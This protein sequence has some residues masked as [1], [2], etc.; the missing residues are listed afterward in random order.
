M[1]SIAAR[2]AGAHPDLVTG[3]LPPPWRAIVVPLAGWSGLVLAGHVLI[4]SL[5]AAGRDIGLRAPPL[6]G[7]VE[8]RPSLRLAA[9]LGVAAAVVL[10]GPPLAARMPWRRLVLLSAAMA[11]AWAVALA[12]VDG[13]DRLT[14][15]P[16]SPSGYLAVAERLVSPGAF[17]SSFT[18]RL[19]SY[20]IHVQGHP[21]GLVTA[22]WG[23][24]RVGLGGP[25]LLAALSIAGGGAAVAA[26]LVGAREVAGEP[27][28][29]RAAPFVVLAPAAVWVAT[30]GD[31][32]FAGIGAWAVTLVVLATG[33]FERR[34]DG[35]A[36]AGG[37]LF[38][39][40]AFLSYGLVLLALIPTAVAW[41][42]RRLRPLVVAAAG[43]APVALA[44]LAGGFWWF[45]GLHA[46]RERY[47]AGVGGRRPYG[48]FLV[49]DLAV[50][51]L[52][53]GP[54][55]AVGLAR[56]R[57]RA[58]WLLVGGALAAIA[59]ADVS[60]MSK[61]EVE[62]IWL[63]FMP[64]VLLAGAALYRVERDRADR[65]RVWLSLQA[66]VAITIQ[67]LVRSPW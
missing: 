16:Q 35:L 29:R 50:L 52:A 32:L 3:D 42:R 10:A 1:T 53:V 11:V 31:A 56:L 34:S 63:P 5:R 8:W 20:P 21:P 64:W 24:D 12:L 59:V 58:G 46:T 40:T 4:R 23:L 43:A 17:L 2:G 49:A 26:A 22:L 33:Q 54:A 15:E 38:G 37:F 57:D 48:A 39:V 66:A 27:W 47:F 25:V 55:I 60:G 45:D 6:V 44:F 9:A 67:T 61:G 7:V 30:S 62:R 65:T 36:L 13:V 19:A 18:D 14:S 51:A 28:A 41:R